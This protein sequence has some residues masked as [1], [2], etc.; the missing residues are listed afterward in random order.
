MDHLPNQD[1]PNVSIPFCA[2]ARIYKQND[3]FELPE[4]YHGH[5]YLME[6]GLRGMELHEAAAFLQA[7]LFF[8]LLAEVF[9]ASVDAERYKRRGIDGK[10]RVSTEDLKDDIEKWLKRDQA[11]ESS[12]DNEYKD[13]YKAR[14]IKTTHALRQARAFISKWGSDHIFDHAKTFDIGNDEWCQDEIFDRLFL[15]FAIL[16]ET[17]ERDRPSISWESPPLNWIS[18]NGDGRPWGISKY[19]T[20]SMRKQGWCPRDIQRLQVTG[21]DVCSVYYMSTIRPPHVMQNESHKNC[22]FQECRK[23]PTNNGHRHIEPNCSCELATPDS[24]AIRN[25]VM[26][27]NIPLLTWTRDGA[28]RVTA[29]EIRDE[30]PS[31]NDNTSGGSEFGAASHVWTDGLGYDGVARGLPTCQI[32][33]LRKSFSELRASES[34]EKDMPFWIDT[35]CIPEDYEARKKAIRKI[36]EVYR[37][38]WTVLVI[39][40]ELMETSSQTD[41]LEPAVRILTGRWTQRL[42]TLQE[43]ILTRN[44]HFKFRDGMLSVNNLRDRY[45]RAK[46]DR[47]DAYHHSWKAGWLFSPSIRSISGDETAKDDQDTDDL[48]NRRV[49]HLWRSVQWRQAQQNSDETI[50]LATI[51]DIDPSPLI[52]IGAHDDTSPPSE[53]DRMVKFLELLDENLGIPSGLIFLPGPKLPIDGYRWAPRTWMSRLKRESPSIIFPETIRP[54]YLTRRGLFVEYPGVYLTMS[55]PDVPARF[56]LPVSHTLVTWY[57]IDAIPAPAAWK[58]IWRQAYESD[59]R[60]AVILSRQDPEEDPELALLVEISRERD[61]V[62]WVQILCRL[63]VRLETNHNVITKLK[64]DWSINVKKMIW[65]EKLGENQKWIVDGGPETMVD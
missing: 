21:G 53:S 38:A 56:W 24:T 36:G 57:R 31:G 45:K 22:T 11:H 1:S 12:N 58:Q 35:L 65:G 42:W 16:G 50:C 51:L 14:H 49:S 5:L 13:E 19:V 23:P 3:F 32:E 28:W 52:S 59:K 10:P 54:S 33:D 7:W 47:G 43:G 40:T 48:Q 9:G 4:K 44:L 63:R 27:G 39:A 6:N 60:T 8:S 55:N 20:K 37:R 41:T 18:Q 46:N 2:E 61:G 17:L 25:I 34:K 29:H 62:N 30:S 64:H 15:S 26:E